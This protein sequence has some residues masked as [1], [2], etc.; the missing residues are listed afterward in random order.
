[1]GKGNWKYLL[2]FNLIVVLLGTV[3][4]LEGA[5]HLTSEARIISITG[6]DQMKFDITEIEVK[7]G[8]KIKIILKN[9]GKIPKMGMAHNFVLLNSSVDA[10]N[11]SMAAI[12]ARENEYIPIDREKEIIERL[13]DNLKGKLD[14]KDI[15]KL[16]KP[17]FEISKKFQVEE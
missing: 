5:H 10:K 12:M 1:M 15:T 16:L 17:I 9:V 7:A 2:G 14:R 6:N 8:E 11:F 4:I 3:T 13:A